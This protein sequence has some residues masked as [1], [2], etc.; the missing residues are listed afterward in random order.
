[1]RLCWR[2]RW[3]LYFII[4]CFCKVIL[5]F[6]PVTENQRKMMEMWNPPSPNKEKLFKFHTCSVQFNMAFILKEN[7]WRFTLLHQKSLT[8][9]GK[10]FDIIYHMLLCVIMSYYHV[11][12]PI[13][14]GNIK[15]LGIYYFYYNVLANFISLIHIVLLLYLHNIKINNVLL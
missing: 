2:I 13:I 4:Q 12:R 10:N 8:V 15:K 11:C 6:W 5:N 1:M 7:Y 14:R 3:F 9:Y